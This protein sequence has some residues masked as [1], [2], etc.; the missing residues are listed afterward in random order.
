MCVLHQ[1]WA[2]S[3]DA[4]DADDDDDDDD[5][6][7]DVEEDL[8]LPPQ[9]GTGVPSFLAV[10]RHEIASMYSNL[11]WLAACQFRLSYD[12]RRYILKD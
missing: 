11:L 10:E 2:G 3:D 5:D 1:L 7:D 9:Y 8:A 4:D 6:A 12:E